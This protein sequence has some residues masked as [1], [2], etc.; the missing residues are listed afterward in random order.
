MQPVINTERLTLRELCHDD[1]AFVTE[2]LGDAEVTRFHASPYTPEEASA[3]LERQLDL[4]QDG[5]HGMWL[6]LNRKSG[7]PVGL[8]GLVPQTVDGVSETELV[9][10]IHRK[11]W[12]H[13]YATE[14]AFAVRSL[15]RDRY[16]YSR[17]ISIIDPDNLPSQGVARRLGM[18]PKRTLT[19]N[20]VQH[21]LF[22]ASLVASD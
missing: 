14:A 6:V 10:L 9:Y 7:K 4:Y 20:G 11:H 16:G 5:K 18:Q 21:T 19:W 1:L 22:A 3:W 17:V 8:V 13:G 2:L 12:R 15:A